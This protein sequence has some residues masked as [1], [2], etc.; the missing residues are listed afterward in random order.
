MTDTYTQSREQRNIFAAV[1][2]GP[3]DIPKQLKK[4]IWKLACQ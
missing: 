2:D 3:V 1:Y 4:F